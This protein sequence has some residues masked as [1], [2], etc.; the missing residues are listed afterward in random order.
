METTLNG[1]ISAESVYNSVNNNTNFKK[2][3]ILSIQTRQDGLR[4]KTNSRYCPFKRIDKIRD[5]TNLYEGLTYILTG[6]KVC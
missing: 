4:Q 2:I 6:N 5:R 1:E 3:Q